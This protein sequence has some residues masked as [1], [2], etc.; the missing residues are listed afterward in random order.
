[1]TKIRINAVYYFL[2]SVHYRC[3][4]GDLVD[5]RA[6]EMYLPVSLFICFFSAFHRLVILS[7]NEAAFNLINGD[8]EN[9]GECHVV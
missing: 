6:S 2:V 8:V 4:D 9:R 3:R 7:A 1:M 5:T